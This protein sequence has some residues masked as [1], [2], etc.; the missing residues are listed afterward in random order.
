MELIRHEKE[1]RLLERNSRRFVVS[2]HRVDAMVDDYI[3]C[4]EEAHHLPA[5]QV[6]LPMH[7]SPKKI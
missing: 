4:L 6:E 1:R 5:P 2:E 3:A 7:L